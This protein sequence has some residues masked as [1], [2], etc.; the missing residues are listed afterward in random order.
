MILIDTNV[1][2]ELTKPEPDDRVRLWLYEHRRETLLS[3]LVV[4]EL[5]VG[6]GTTR[7]RANRTLLLG[8]LD[9]LLLRHREGRIV[10]FTL[11]HSLLWGDIASR[12]IVADKRAGF[13]DSL[14]GAQA[15]V[16]GVPVATRNVA[17]FRL[18]GLELVNPWDA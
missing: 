10:P 5:R 16:L 17:D 11:D 13:V 12:M 15:L 6:I 3:T 2:S 9:R 4:A 1:F 18:P 14:L 7:G 8:W